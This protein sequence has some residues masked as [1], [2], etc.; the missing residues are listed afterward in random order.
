MAVSVYLL[1]L[2]IIIIDP[3]TIFQLLLSKKQTYMNN[4]IQ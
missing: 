2:V 3:N 4:F 1:Q